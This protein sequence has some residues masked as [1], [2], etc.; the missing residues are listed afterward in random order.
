MIVYNNLEI[1]YTSY[2]SLFLQVLCD[3]WYMMSPNE[4]K[5]CRSLFPDV[6]SNLSDNV[7]DVILKCLPCKYSTR[8]SILSKKWRYNWCRRTELNLD[9]SHW[10]TKNDL[11][12]PTIILK[13][14]FPSC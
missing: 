7:N 1:A 3:Y 2:Y 13:R 8:T 11:L 14:L 4:R 5:C 12:Y 6:L 10:I 9:K